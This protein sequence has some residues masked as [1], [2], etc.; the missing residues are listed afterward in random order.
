LAVL[1]LEQAGH[2]IDGVAGELSRRGGP[3]TIALTP[4]RPSVDR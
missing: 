4:I 2:A 1:M 3:F